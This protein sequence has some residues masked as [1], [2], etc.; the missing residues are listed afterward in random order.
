M[1]IFPT[2]HICQG[3]IEWEGEEF[4]GA[5]VSTE[6]VPQAALGKAKF[7][8]QGDTACNNHKPLEM[9]LGVDAKPSRLLYKLISL[10]RLTRCTMLHK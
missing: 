2:F 9:A 5:M 4:L 10:G 3:K 1:K 7:T 6:A 8:S